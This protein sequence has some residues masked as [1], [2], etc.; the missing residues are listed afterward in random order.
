MTVPPGVANGGGVSSWSVI[1][2]TTHSPSAVGRAG[3][4]RHGAVTHLR[5]LGS[6]AV[7]YRVMCGAGLVAHV[8]RR[9]ACDLVPGDGVFSQ[10]LPVAAA[11]ATAR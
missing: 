11:S 10:T 1:R 5:A 7:R 9:H 6:V 2:D 4:A 8:R 3:R